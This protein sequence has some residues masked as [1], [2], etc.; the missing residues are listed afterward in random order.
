LADLLLKNLRFRDVEKRA[1]SPEAAAFIE[2]L[3]KVEE[4]KG[5][6]SGVHGKNNYLKCFL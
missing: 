1:S 2:K 3:V 5:A 6:L 4:E